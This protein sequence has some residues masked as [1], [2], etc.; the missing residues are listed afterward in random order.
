M[1]KRSAIR[2]R[3]IAVAAVFAAVY[4]VLR[5][6]PNPIP[7][8]FQMIGISG[9]F[10]AGDFLLTSIALFA[11]LWSGVLAVLIGSVLAY[12]VSG[13]PFLGFDFLP[14]VVNV[15]VTGLILQNHRRIARGLFTAIL[16]LFLL[17]PYSLVFGYGFVPYA[18]LH[19]VGLA[20][21]L[22][23]IVSKIPIWLKRNDRRHQVVAIAVLAFVGT[24]AQH[25]T[26]G[27]LYEFTVGLVQGNPA[28]V[29]RGNWQIIFWLYP[30]ERLIIVA[31]SALVS[32]GLLRS[33]KHLG[34]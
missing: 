6:L 16:L 1:S 25:L 7:F 27:L 28:E 26:G 17:S 23:P 11:G 22:S 33:V 13:T 31:V 15:L 32:T 18:W 12:P 9:R 2:S 30:T 34:V 29:L 24:M 19:V 14:G 5:S 10:T 3:R 21:L 20:L 8:L 4:F